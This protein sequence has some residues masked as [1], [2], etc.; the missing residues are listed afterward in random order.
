MSTNIG[1]LESVEFAELVLEAAQYVM[2]LSLSY[3]LSCIPPPPM[4]HFKRVA[5]SN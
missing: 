2:I 1:G 5:G 3:S 4:R